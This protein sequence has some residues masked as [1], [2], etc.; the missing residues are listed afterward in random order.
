[1]CSGDQRLKSPLNSKDLNGNTSFI[2]YYG[3]DP[4]FKPYPEHRPELYH[5]DELYTKMC[6]IKAHIRR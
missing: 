4:L 3:T 1:M 5:R 2:N 6:S